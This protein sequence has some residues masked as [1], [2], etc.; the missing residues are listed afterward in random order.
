[1]NQIPCTCTVEDLG[2]MNYE[3]EV[4]GALDFSAHRRVYSFKAA[5]E[6]DAAMQAMQDF[7]DEIEALLYVKDA[8]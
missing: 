4:T 7:V 5:S 6:K 3:V 2:R 1:M 8:E